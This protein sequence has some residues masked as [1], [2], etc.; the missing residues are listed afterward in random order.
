MTPIDPKYLANL[1][2]MADNV[3]PGRRELGT[4]YAKADEIWDG[5]DAEQRIVVWTQTHLTL[6]MARVPMTSA[7]VEWF[8]RGMAV[9]LAVMNPE[10]APMAMATIAACRAFARG[11]QMPRRAVEFTA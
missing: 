3:A 6:Q 5:L 10:Y 4:V 2:E 11:E 7:A 9:T 8:A 1:Q